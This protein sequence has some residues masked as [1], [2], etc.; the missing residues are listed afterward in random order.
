MVADVSNPREFAPEVI[1]GC[2]TID[3]DVAG[4]SGSTTQNL[5]VDPRL[6]YQRVYVALADSGIGVIDVSN[7]AQ[8]TVITKITEDIS[9]RPLGEVTNI[10][11]SVPYLYIHGYHLEDP[12]ALYDIS[13]GVEQLDLLDT[14]TA[15]GW[16]VSIR[17]NHD[18][19]A[20]AWLDRIHLFAEPGLAQDDTDPPAPV[21][22]M[23]GE[24]VV[25]G[26]LLSWD[27]PSPQDDRI[28]VK[29]IR[30]ADHF[31]AN[32]FDGEIIYDGFES[33]A[34]DSQNIESGQTYYYTAFAYD[35]S[36]NMSEAWP[37]SSVQIQAYGFPGPVTRLIAVEQCR[38]IRL[39]W[40]NPDD[41]DWYETKIVRSVADYPVEISDGIVVY[42]GQDETIV[43][44]T[45]V[46]NET[47]YY[48]SAFST[49]LYGD[50]IT[51]EENAQ[52]HATPNSIIFVDDFESEELG[53]PPSQW[54]EPPYPDIPIICDDGSRPA[55]DPTTI[56]PL[57]SRV[58]SR[59][60]TAH[61]HYYFGTR[62]I[63]HESLLT[64]YT[65]NMD[66]YDPLIEQASDT[67]YNRFGLEFGYLDEDNY[68]RFTFLPY[69][70]SSVEFIYFV[71]GQQIYSAGHPFA[72]DHISDDDWYHVKLDV[73]DTHLRVTVDGIKVAEV[74]DD[75]IQIRNNSPG[76]LT[77][78]YQLTSGQFGIGIAY[79]AY[80]DNITIVGPGCCQMA[81]D[82]NNDAGVAVGD[83][84]FIINFVFKGGS[85]PD[86][87]SAADANAD[88]SINI[89]DAV[90]LINYIFKDGDP[91]IC[92]CYSW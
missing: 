52:D 89:G 63:T 86:C 57:D 15:A 60:N 73:H 83:A 3:N 31:P 46:D 81:G 80:V 82:A 43:D 39:T 4:L 24:S 65:V 7:P 17:A 74:V 90:T 36:L 32:A 12:L 25:G 42:G 56:P 9:G 33:D 59:E 64:T 85:A 51:P 91:P 87:E 10:F 22:G 84:V 45:S 54:T 13:G 27:D 75:D 6:L 35:Y 30:N 55:W 16:R 66:I 1:G 28:A 40:T 53:G 2:E 20:V 72:I 61:L 11:I 77:Q 58:M 48:Y 92:G 68:T 37:G 47:T 78:P 62:C 79:G 34:I 8:P 88:Y 26:I 49:N 23:T 14:M 19:G 21:T 29:I 69:Y 70:R 71:D 5:A 50:Y 76:T 18:S 38:S 44:T 67:H 41:I